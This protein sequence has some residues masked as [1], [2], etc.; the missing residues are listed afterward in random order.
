MTDKLAD[1]LSDT[2]K[3]R[4]CLPYLLVFSP[5]RCAPNF[6]PLSLQARNTT[7]CCSAQTHCKASAHSAVS[8]LYNIPINK[9]PRGVGRTTVCAILS[10]VE[11][12]EILYLYTALALAENA[13]KLKHRWSGRGISKLYHD[14][15]SHVTV[16]DKKSECTVCLELSIVTEARDQCRR[17]GERE[18]E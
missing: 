1:C 8:Y 2:Q 16:G 18:R 12:K 14:D 10:C 17:G 6:S 4:R 13:L 7:S 5:S 11:P 15:V 3:Q 9:I